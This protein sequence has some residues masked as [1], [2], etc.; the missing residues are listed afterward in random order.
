M[1]NVPDRLGFVRH[2]GGAVGCPVV[3]LS[4]PAVIGGMSCC[5]RASLIIVES[6]GA[7]AESVS[8]F[9]TGAFS[10]IITSQ[11]YWYSMLV[12]RRSDANFLVL[13]TPGLRQLQ[14]SRLL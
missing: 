1:E 14:G 7:P 6:E 3:D 8:M 2:G 11:P 12:H 9:E 10:L 4:S 13:A 5:T